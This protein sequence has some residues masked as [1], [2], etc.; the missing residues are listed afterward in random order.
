MLSADVALES[1]P[2]GTILALIDGQRF[3]AEHEGETLI[4]Y[5]YSDGG[6]TVPA[7]RAGM[8]VRVGAAAELKLRLFQS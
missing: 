3:R 4:V 5:G 8:L 7:P 6:R 2:D 1:L